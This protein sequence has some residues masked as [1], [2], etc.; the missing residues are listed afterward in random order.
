MAIDFRSIEKPKYFKTSMQISPKAHINMQ[1][2]IQ[3]YIDNSLSKTCNLP[4]ETTFEEYQELLWYAIK[5]GVKGFTTFRSGTREGVLN[6]KK[7]DDSGSAKEGVKVLPIDNVHTAVV[8]SKGSV[9]RERV[10]DGKTYQIKD[11]TKKN[12]Y[13][14]INSFVDDGVKKPWEIFLFSKSAHSEWYAAMGVLMSSIMRKVGDVHFI[15]DDLKDISGDS[16]Y[17]TPEYGFVGSKPAHIGYILEE[18]INNLNG[19]EK[20]PSMSHCPS[21]KEMSLVREGGCNKCQSCGY[22]DCG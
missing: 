9:V 14:T 6:E 19:I 2:L 5:S 4:E 22:S 3:K 1:A 17:F 15:I 10:L 8:S 20:A 18:Y 7:K 13:I 21:C 16:G 11:D 12:T